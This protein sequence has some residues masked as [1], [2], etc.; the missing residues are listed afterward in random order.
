MSVKLHGSII[1]TY[2]CNARCN[3]C[4]VWENPTRASEEISIKVIEKLPKMFFTNITG[5]EVFIRK[6]LPEI[7]GAIRKK[8]KRIVISTN[9]YFTDRI[10]D[11]CKRYPDLGIR[12]SIEGLPKANDEI[13]GIPDGFDRGIRTLLKLRSMGIKDI[14]FGMTI[15][16]KNCKDILPLYNLA[17]ALGYEF[18]TSTLHN[19]HY[20]HK[21]DNKVLDKGTV[22]GEI[23]KLIFEL[24]RSKRVKDWFRAYVNL[25]FINFIYGKPR[26]LPCEMGKNGFFVD[27]WGDILAC[28]G[29]EKKYSM[30]NLCK[31]SWDE[32]WNSVQAERVRNKVTM[33]QRNCWM[34]GSAA[35][36]IWE[37]PAGPIKW[38]IKNKLKSMMDKEFK[39]TV[40]WQKENL[41]FIPYVKGQDENIL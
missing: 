40:K 34:I 2:R 11:L 23:E 13:R 6:D 7:V 36:A 16:D 24:L 18:A 17:Q 31:Q 38:V 33:C 37:H 27:P 8:T 22:C 9:G 32:I 4:N 3:M 12:I 26:L 21:L 25:G 41:E 30:G 28:N 35:P 29:M 19:S 1:L 20:F 15:Q 10:V 14:G 5:G 39:L